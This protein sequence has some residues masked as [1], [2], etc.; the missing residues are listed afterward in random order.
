MRGNNREQN[1][2]DSLDLVRLRKSSMVSQRHVVNEWVVEYDVTMNL[3]KENQVIYSDKETI[4][5][6]FKRLSCFAFYNEDFRQTKSSAPLLQSRLTSPDFENRTFAKGQKKGEGYV[7][8][9]PVG[10]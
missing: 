9:F 5:F 6:L 4:M 7:Y 1:L 8:A 3:F 2:R 10:R